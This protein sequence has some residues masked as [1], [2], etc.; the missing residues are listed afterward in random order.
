[1]IVSGLGVQLIRLREEDLELVR[2]WR[3]SP[4]IAGTMQYRKPISEA[5]QKEWF[6]S[7][8]N[9]HNFYYIISY[10]KEKIG[11]INAK[12]IDWNK[13]SSEGGMFVWDKKYI[14]THVPLLASLCMLESAFYF[15]R[16]KSSEINVLRDNPAAIEYAVNLGYEAVPDQEDK[17]VL[18]C[19]LTQEKFSDAAAHLKNALISLFSSQTEFTL[20]IETFDYENGVGNFVEEK[21]KETFPDIDETE[22]EGGRFFRKLVPLR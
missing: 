7:V 17:E 11:L 10:R 13:R 3:N 16:W 14:N 12:N 9:I 5:M 6:Q 20:F 18:K 2:Y 19:I 15:F 21:L 8:N 1:M 22:K 4:E